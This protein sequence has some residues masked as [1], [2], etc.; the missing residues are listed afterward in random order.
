MNRYSAGHTVVDAGTLALP[1]L[2]YAL[3]HSLYRQ[4]A[5]SEPWYAI[6]ALW[7]LGL[8][9][10]YALILVH[11]SGHALVGWLAGIEIS[12][13]TIGHWRKIGTCRV[14][15]VPVTFRAAPAT[16]YVS[17]KPSPRCL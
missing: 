6:P 8:G 9:I 5:Y 14:G 3:S 12:G 15:G 10:A 16:G 4:Y 17:I 1:L 7:L 2:P 11:E 13:V